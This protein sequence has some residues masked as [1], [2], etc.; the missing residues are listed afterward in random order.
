MNTESQ[1]RDSCS[2]D[3]VGGSV[4]SGIHREWTLIVNRWIRV[5]RAI[6]Q[7]LKAP[8]TAIK[9][10]LYLK[11]FQDGAEPSVIAD[12]ICI[13]RQTMTSI[14]VGME[15]DGLVVRRDHPA[16]RRRRQ[17]HLSPDGDA[18]ATRIL[19]EIRRYEAQAAAAL[20]PDEFATMLKLMGKYSEALEKAAFTQLETAK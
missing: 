18:L 14:L 6:Y 4:P 15:A 9:T 1:H 10:L 17:I 8:S 20:D 2:D 11:L 16:D 3:T 7:R 12:F 13:P 19:K 5:V